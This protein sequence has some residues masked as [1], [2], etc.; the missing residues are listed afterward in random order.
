[1][2]AYSVFESATNNFIETVMAQSAYDALNMVALKL[3]RPI[4]GLYARTY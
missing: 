4:G 1:M 2:K 3:N